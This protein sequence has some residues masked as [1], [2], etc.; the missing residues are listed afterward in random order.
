MHHDAAENEESPVHINHVR[1]LQAALMARAST[2]ACGATSRAWTSGRRRRPCWSRGSTTARWWWR[3]SCTWWRPTARSATT[4]LWTA[5]RPCPPC[6]TPWTTAPPPPAAGGCTPSARSPGTSPWPSRAT[7]LSPTAGIW[8]AA[9]R[10]PPGPSLPKLWRSKASST[11]SGEEG[12]V[13]LH[14]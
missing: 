9:E 6:C 1:V 14:V 12:S 13:Q 10:C 2:T 11:S 7:T 3:A 4:T 8:S 5:G